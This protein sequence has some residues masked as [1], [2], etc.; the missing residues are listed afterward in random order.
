MKDIAPRDKLDRPR[1]NLTPFGPCLCPHEMSLAT[2]L[3]P[4]HL[5]FAICHL[6]SE[7]SGVELHVSFL[8]LHSMVNP[9]TPNPRIPESPEPRSPS[10]PTLHPSSNPESAPRG[11]A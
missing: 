5:L 6:A 4:R 3:S 7:W 2:G 10:A 8:S 11:A 1:L 9:E